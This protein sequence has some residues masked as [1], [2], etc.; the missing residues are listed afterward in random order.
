MKHLIKSGLKGLL[1]MSTMAA[2]TELN[3]QNTNVF[4]LNGNAGIG[5]LSPGVPLDIVKP[6]NLAARLRN[7]TTSATADGS[8]I[9]DMTNSSNV[10][11]RTI[12]GGKNNGLGINAGQY[13]I[14]RSGLGAT[15][16][17]D[18]AGLVGI[19]TE[20]PG[21]QLDVACYS[22]MAGRFRNINAATTADGSALI[23]ITN[24]Q[25]NSWRIGTAGRN[26]GIGLESNQFY[27]ERSGYGPYL[28]INTFGNILIAKKTQTN[29][30]YKLDVAGKVRANEVVVNT[31]G[32]DF[33]FA[34]DYKMSTLKEV[35]SFVKTN[36]HL[37]GIASAAEMTEKGMEVGELTKT[38]LQKVEELTLYIIEQQ[39]QIDLLKANAAK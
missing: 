10:L 39:K 5:T 24:S 29:T 22:Y 31:T 28:T 17:I 20:T 7:N 19:N 12:V 14:E 13:Y 30:S 33:V 2:V 21:A 8:V 27:I 37:P 38:L 34:D 3:A 18:Q 6:V 15:F 1:L 32:A 16:L 11:W 23:D 35:E 26:N 25:G 9:F 4:P 36:K